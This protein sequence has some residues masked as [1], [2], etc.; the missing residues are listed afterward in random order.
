[1]YNINVEKIHIQKQT[2]KERSQEMSFKI[3]E[4][5]NIKTSY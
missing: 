1:M 3:N 2:K 5:V 4:Y